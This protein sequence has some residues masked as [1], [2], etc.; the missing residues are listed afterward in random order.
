MK[1]SSKPIKEQ[2]KNREFL[3]DIMIQAG[4]KPLS[5]EWWHFNG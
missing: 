4:F 1:L 2:S 3:A 5:F